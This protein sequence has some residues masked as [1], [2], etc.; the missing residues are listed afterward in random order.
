MLYAMYFVF[1][2]LSANTSQK[3]DAHTKA[4]LRRMSAAVA[5]AFSDDT[6]MLL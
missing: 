6:A 4:N 3:L 2:C 1:V 5:Q